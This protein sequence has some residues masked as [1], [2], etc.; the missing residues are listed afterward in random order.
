[1]GG[2]HHPQKSKKATN[3]KATNNKQRA[4]NKKQ[5]AQKKRTSYYRSSFLVLKILL[6]THFASRIITY[7]LDPRWRMASRTILNS[8]EE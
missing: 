1:M 3:K 5:T 4:N 7:L 6:S 2:S 8:S